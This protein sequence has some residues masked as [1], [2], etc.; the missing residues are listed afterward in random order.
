MI[1]PRQAVNVRVRDRTPIEVGMRRRRGCVVEP[2]INVDG[3]AEPR[4]DVTG[5]LEL[6]P[7]PPAFPDEGRRDQEERRESSR[8]WLFRED[9]DENG[10]ADRVAYENSVVVER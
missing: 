2:V 8:R 3:T 7:R 1:A 5:C 9:V 10:T 6:V 4:R